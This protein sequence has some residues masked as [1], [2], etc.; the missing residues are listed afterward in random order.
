MPSNKSTI[1][2]YLEFHHEGNDLQKAT[3]QVGKFEEAGRKAGDG[4]SFLDVSLGNLASGGVESLL[5][6]A[7]QA[8]GMLFEFGAQSAE[9]A[10]DARETESLLNS[11]LGPAYDSFA[12]SVNAVGDA[13]GRST[14]EFKQAVAPILAM[15]K[16]Q[17]FAS[18]AAGE[19]SVAFGS[20]ALD[21][22]SYF[23]S[24][25]GFED[26]QSALAGSSE[27]LQKYGINANVAALQQEA[28]NLGLIDAIGP[29][30]QQT[31]TTALLALVQR[32]AS[33]AM[34]DA[35]RT[36]GDYA[37]VQRSLVDLWA[38]FKAEVGDSL[39]D[40][41]GPAQKEL[42]VLAKQV[43]PEVAKRISA[44][45]EAAVEFGSGIAQIT[46]GVKGFVDENR[47]LVDILSETAD[48][49]N[50]LDLTPLE[51]LL[52]PV[53][54]N[55]LLDAAEGI[56][57]SG[58]ETMALADATERL[59]SA[60]STGSGGR[61]GRG[62]IISPEPVDTS[63]FDTALKSTNNTLSNLNIGDAF[64]NFETST[65]SLNSFF[66][67]IDEN[68]QASI[69][70]VQQIGS[71]FSGLRD[72]IENLNT[73]DILGSTGNA[74]SGAIDLLAQSA[75][76]LG[77]GL[78][79]QA[80]ILESAGFA[81]SEID[82]R[83]RDILE[84]TVA[85]Y[86]AAFVQAGNP[87][88][89]ALQLIDDFQAQIDSTDNPIDLAINDTLGLQ[90]ALAEL[91]S[92]TF[93]PSVNFQVTGTEELERAVALL[94]E[95]SGADSSVGAVLNNSFVSNDIAGNTGRRQ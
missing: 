18:E 50:F 23:N 15:T 77:L 95:V 22:N 70:N 27:T 12:D 10:S 88:E 44:G 40:A 14:R 86:A 65:D 46:A 51:L 34:G 3:K 7:G 32:Q 82:T 93:A 8:I 45:V 73:A 76:G 4:I 69:D 49:F 33:D 37:N 59:E 79:D 19:T 78:Q 60:R 2:T 90:E 89:E 17:G 41:I 57:Q 68:T 47:F 62:S 87:V 74:E 83:A 25:T 28:L 6:G 29:L 26:L 84:Q 94:N 9:I 80:S 30:D 5:S 1:D 54:G 24:T 16:A 53:G 36:A 42:S 39:V 58:E 61:G 72:K 92:S 91:G 52:A 66:G 38:D 43:L 64:G 71:A 13:T 67:T 21:L 85:D 20:A 56:R 63:S 31:R 81:Q 55:A 11:A 35:T 48:Q 75:G